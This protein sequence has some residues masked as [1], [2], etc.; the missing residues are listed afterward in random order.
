MRLRYNKSMSTAKKLFSLGIAIMM[1]AIMGI[2]LTPKKA[3]ALSGSEFQ[4]GNII[5]DGV[6]FN[7]GDMSEQAIQAFLNSKVPVCDTWGT[8]PRGGTT[9]AAYGTS[10]G[11]PPPYV[12]LK[13]FVQE[14]LPIKHAENGLCTGL[15]PGTKTAARIIYEVSISCGI[16]PKVLLVLLQKEQSLVTDDWPWSIQY[17]SA[18]GYGCPD[19]APCDAEYYGFFNQVYHAA[20]QYKRYARDAHL[21]NF[22]AGMNNYIQWHP[23][24]ACGGS[25]VFIQNQATAGLYNYTPYQPNAAALNN[26]Y[27]TG[28]GCSAYGNRNFWR[29]YNDWFGSTHISATCNGTEQQGSYVRRFYNPRTFQHFYSAKDCDVDFLQRL[30]FRNEGP[31]FNTTPANSPLATPVY[32]LYNPN[33]KLHF[34]TT[35][36]E[37]PE[38]L[39][40][41][42]SGYRHEAGIVFYVLPN[43]I[44][45]P[46]NRVDRFYNPHTF[47]N[48]WGPNT[49]QADRD[50][51]YF[52]G[53]YLYTGPVWNTQ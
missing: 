4:A 27:G 14:N 43:N 48:L 1:M 49:S 7:G 39:A 44:P 37:T 17:R 11:Y 29:L 31:S 2:G 30:G 16:N 52:Q 19:T 24:A 9:R 51:L 42:G 32:R 8:Q 26:L 23:N 38:Q 6:F 45:N 20:R 25:H 53:H 47:V 34:W 15:G 5:S 3:D 13:D 41:G 21:F 40:A 33:T 22:R 28:D 10:V 50:F 12:C 35:H 36:Y 46:P 18:T